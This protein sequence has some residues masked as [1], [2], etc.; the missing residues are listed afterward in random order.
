MYMFFLL[1]SYVYT[2]NLAMEKY[3]RSQGYTI[4]FHG[5]GHTINLYFALVHRTAQSYDPPEQGEPIRAQ[6]REGPLGPR[7]WRA[8]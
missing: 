3:K 2:F 8:H 4:P 5:V 1:V 6:T 7:P